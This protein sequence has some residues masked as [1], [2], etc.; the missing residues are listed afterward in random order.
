MGMHYFVV[1][2]PQSDVHTM[3]PLW[4]S[5]LLLQRSM[6]RVM[7]GPIRV[8]AFSPIMKPWSPS[9]ITIHR[10]TP[11]H[12]MAL[13]RPLLL[14]CLRFNIN[15]AARYIPG[16]FNILADNLSRSRIPRS[17]T[18]GKRQPGHRPVHH[19]PSRLRQSLSL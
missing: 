6:C 9:L 11:T 10:G 17:G 7:L 8:P 1:C 16:R 4:N 14:A 15:C 2:G 18:W 19:I 13:I 3:S 12:I 5:T